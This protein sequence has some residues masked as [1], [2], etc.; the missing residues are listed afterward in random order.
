MK[1]NYG[2]TIKM[3]GGKLI[4]PRTVQEKIQHRAAYK[5]AAKE[6][7]DLETDEELDTLFELLEGPDGTEHLQ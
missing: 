1:K 3:D 5:K 7:I 2:V 4:D 6:V